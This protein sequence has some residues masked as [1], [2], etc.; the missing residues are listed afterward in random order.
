MGIKK[1]RK[2]AE[3]HEW[4]STWVAAFEAFAK[5]DEK[6]DEGEKKSAT[7]QKIC[8]ACGFRNWYDSEEAEP[9]KCWKCTR[10]FPDQPFKFG[11]GDLVK[12]KNGRRAIF[13]RYRNKDTSAS[14]WVLV[15]DSEGDFSAHPWLVEGL[16]LIQRGA[17]AISL[18]K[19]KD[20]LTGS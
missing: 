3:D 15:I 18:K 1:L 9:P 5:P 13:Q 19:M 2:F 11:E 6:P 16:E 7:L 10:S 4:S 12:N 14:C 17:F 20:K 8:P